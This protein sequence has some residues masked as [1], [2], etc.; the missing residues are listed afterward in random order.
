MT[1][2]RRIALMTK[3]PQTTNRRNRNLFFLSEMAFFTFLQP[4]IFKHSNVLSKMSY[5][6]IENIQS[7]YAPCTVSNLKNI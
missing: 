3:N 6:I 2:K 1:W 5:P 4:P 7:V